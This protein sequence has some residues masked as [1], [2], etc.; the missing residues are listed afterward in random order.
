ML[1]IARALVRRPKILL[2]DE[3]LEGLAPKIVKT[4]TKTLRDIREEGVGLFIT[5]PGN[6]KRVK[7]LA[8][9]A[10]GIDRGEIVY[11]GNLDRILQDPLARK[12]IW[13]L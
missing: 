13:G 10:Y 4:I 8:E 3:P 5:E 9:K 7:P 12:R 2:L 1:A 11:S 6:I